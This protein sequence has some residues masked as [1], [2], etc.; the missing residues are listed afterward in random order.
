MIQP[1]Q[2]LWTDGLSGDTEDEDEDEVDL[3]DIQTRARRNK[4]KK[5]VNKR[6]K[7]GRTKIS[8]S[9][10]TSKEL[11]DTGL[12]IINHIHSCHII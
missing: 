3:F 1:N 2:S 5:P 7:G 6:M 11:G 9:V 12:L 8:K 10:E 4:R